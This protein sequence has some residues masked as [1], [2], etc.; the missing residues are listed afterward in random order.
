M[1]KEEIHMKTPIINPYESTYGIPI[2]K[3]NLGVSKNRSQTKT[4]LK[5]KRYKDLGT[6]KDFLNGS[7]SNFGDFDQ[8]YSERLNQSQG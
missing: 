1:I 6:E 4:P 5:Y 3:Q 8:N 7:R 2:M